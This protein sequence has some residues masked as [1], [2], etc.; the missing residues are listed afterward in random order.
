MKRYDTFE[1]AWKDIMP[2][3]YKNDSAR[4]SRLERH[5]MYRSTWKSF[6]E[7]KS[8]KGAHNEKL[9][10]E[11]SADLKKRSENRVVQMRSIFQI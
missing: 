3:K 8:L 2:E 11:M 5:L 1:Q 7:A 6:K 10:H 4:M 9:P